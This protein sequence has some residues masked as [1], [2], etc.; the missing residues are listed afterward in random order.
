MLDVLFSGLGSVVRSMV[1][2]TLGGMSVVGRYFMVAGFVM[3]CSLAMVASRMFVVFGCFMMMFCRLL[4]H[5]SSLEFGA[6][7]APGSLRPRW[8]RRC[9]KIVNGRICNVEKG[10]GKRGWAHVGDRKKNGKALR[11]A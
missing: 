1:Q 4:G 3:L 5:V 7:L 9:Q 11:R 2:V 8:L 6:G 10:G